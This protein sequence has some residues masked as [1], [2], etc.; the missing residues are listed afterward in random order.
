MTKKTQ[1]AKKPNNVGRNPNCQH[2]NMLNLISDY[3]HK[4]PFHPQKIDK[5]YF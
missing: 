5:N 3:N 2:E 4:R 1:Q